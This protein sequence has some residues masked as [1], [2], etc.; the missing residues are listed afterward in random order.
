MAARADTTERL[1]RVEIVDQAT[2]ATAD[3]RPVQAA[4]EYADTIVATADGRPVRAASIAAVDGGAIMPVALFAAGTLST[5]DGRPVHALSFF[6]ASGIAQ[7]LN[8]GDGPPFAGHFLTGEYSVGGETITEPLTSEGAYI[9]AYSTQGGPLTVTPGEGIVSES[10]DEDHGKLQSLTITAQATDPLIA[11]GGLV[12]VVTGRMEHDG[13]VD[14]PDFGYFNICLYVEYCNQY[15]SGAGVLIRRESYD[16]F[17]TETQTNTIQQVTGALYEIVPITF[18]AGGE[19]KAAIRFLN[20]GY[21][22]SSINGSAPNTGTADTAFDADPETGNGP[23]VFLG[24]RT[25][26]TSR[27]QA[28]RV[29]VTDLELYAQDEYADSDLA[30]LSTL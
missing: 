10:P 12:A 13:P 8:G 15:A 18:G 19:F 21:I 29:V 3:G 27:G 26:V 22:A 4:S 2:L 23:P 20:D 25:E 14:A 17:G 28:C 11:G 5:P 16:E 7:L 1:Q 30:A 9:I 24:L 6:D